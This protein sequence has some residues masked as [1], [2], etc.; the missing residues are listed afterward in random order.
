MK[1]KKTTISQQKKQTPLP[2][3]QVTLQEIKDLSVEIPVLI[4]NEV[5]GFFTTKWDR[6]EYLN[7]LEKFKDREVKILSDEK[8][9]MPLFDDKGDPLLD[10]D[11]VENINYN[12]NMKLLRMIYMIRLFGRYMDF[13]EDDDEA[14]EL[15]HNLGTDIFIEIDKLINDIINQKFVLLEEKKK[16]MMRQLLSANVFEKKIIDN[17]NKK[18][19]TQV[20]RI[21]RQ[22]K[23]LRDKLKVCK[24]EKEKN[25]L[26]EKFKKLQAELDELDKNRGKTRDNQSFEYGI[27]HNGVLLRTAQRNFWS[28][29]FTMKVLFNR[30]SEEESIYV[31]LCF[32]EFSLDGEHQNSIYAKMEKD[33]N[34]DGK[35]K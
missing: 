18:Y 25:E 1:H 9:N 14:I 19:K 4:Q 5:W 22:I 12:K 27:K 11:D 10:K 23:I 24:D 13:P 16:K 17:E 32:V 33:R 21:E 26:E 31:N 6:E 28:P 15:L 30:L 8:T 2:L 3:K 29:E 34:K 7:I 20:E 35:D